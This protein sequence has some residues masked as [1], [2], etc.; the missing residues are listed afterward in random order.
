MSISISP[1]GSDRTVDD[2][3]HLADGRPLIIW[4]DGPGHSRGTGATGTVYRLDVDRENYDHFYTA[5]APGHGAVVENHCVIEEKRWESYN[6]ARLARD[7]EIREAVR[8]HQ[9]GGADLLDTDSLQAVLD[10]LKSYPL[11]DTTWLPDGTIIQA[12]REGREVAA[13]EILEEEESVGERGVD[14]NPDEAVGGGQDE[15]GEIPF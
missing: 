15:T 12:I 9:A 10:D 4:N 8:I 3:Y 5:S 14:D 11:L 2:P 13:A 7:A 1:E 6:A